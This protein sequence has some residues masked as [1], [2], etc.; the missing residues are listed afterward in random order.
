VLMENKESHVAFWHKSAEHNVRRHFEATCS[1]PR[2]TI[3]NFEE[4]DCY[5]RLRIRKPDLGEVS[6]LIR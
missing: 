1:E 4:L 6:R 5:S 2:Q 3:L